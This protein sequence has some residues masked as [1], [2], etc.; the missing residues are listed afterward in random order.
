MENHIIYVTATLEALDIQLFP[1]DQ[2]DVRYKTPSTNYII[3]STADTFPCCVKDALFVEISIL[4]S[5][6]F[7]VYTQT[8]QVVIRYS[9]CFYSLNKNLKQFSGIFLSCYKQLNPVLTLLQGCFLSAYNGYKI[10]LGFVL[11]KVI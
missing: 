6:E 11:K 9:P 5:S 7:K 4:N 1:S 8:S 3:F 10:F 2:N